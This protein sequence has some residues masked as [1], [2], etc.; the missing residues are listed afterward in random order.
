MEG[1]SP[2]ARDIHQNERTSPKMGDL[3]HGKVSMTAL[4]A[5]GEAS[6]RFSLNAFN[7]MLP[8]IPPIVA[9]NRHD[10]ASI[11]FVIIN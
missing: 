8:Q 6:R 7:V 2:K 5:I 9:S 1:K 10:V 3:H 11:F 4:R